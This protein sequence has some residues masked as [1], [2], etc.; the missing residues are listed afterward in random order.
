MSDDEPNEFEA[1]LGKP[2]GQPRNRPRT[3]VAEVL[4]AVAEQGGDPRRLGRSGGQR[5]PT[6]RFNARG[7][8]RE[9]AAAL[10]GHG[11][12]ESASGEPWTGGMR[13]R[14]RRVIVKARVVKLNGVEG[15]AIAAHLRYL[16]REG[17]TTDGQHGQAY[18]R[19]DDRADTRAFIER[20][21][22]DRHSSGSSLPPRTASRSGVSSPSRAS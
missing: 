6:G 21:L 9:A 16:Q 2:R 3:F 12:W 10:Q 20:G 13:Y 11:G 19:E 15:Q 17:V 18:S 4:R 14:A 22:E 7:R 5:K 8:G 1:L